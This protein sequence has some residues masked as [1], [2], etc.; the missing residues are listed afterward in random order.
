MLDDAGYLH[1]SWHKVF[2]DY[3]IPDYDIVAED[4]AGYLHFSWHK[5]FYDYVIPDYDIVAEDVEL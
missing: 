2:Y 3:V 1:F 4:D 5:V